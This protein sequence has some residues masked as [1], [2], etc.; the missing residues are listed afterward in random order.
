MAL[1]TAG[2]RSAASR[3]TIQLRIAL[4]SVVFVLGL[5]LIGAAS[6]IGNG[7]LTAAFEDH[8]AYS[9]LAARS[10]EVRAASFALKALSRDVR[11]RQESTDIKDFG[12]GLESLKQAITRLGSAAGADR[13]RDS[14]VALDAPMKAIEAD[15]TAIGAMQLGLRAPAPEG[16]AARLEEAAEALETK[17]RSNSMGS[18]SPD[19]ARLPGILAALRRIDASYRLSLDESLLGQW[20][21]EQG[22]FERALGRQGVSAEAKTEIGPAFTAY[23]EI[24]PAW[25]KAEKDFM[26]AAE[27]LSG[28]FD[29]IAP[30]LQ[31][32]ETRLAAEEAQ[33]GARLAEAQ[34]RTQAII[35]GTIAAALVLGLIAA[36]IVGRTTALPLR[37]LRDAMLKLAAGD[38]EVAI[39]G[40]SRRDEIGQMAQAVQVFKENGLSVQRLEAETSEGRAEAERQNL[41]I[42]RQREEAASAQAS[43]LTEQR[44]VVGLLAEALARL[45][46]GDLTVRIEDAVASDYETLK[47]DFNTAIERLAATVDAIKATSIEVATAGREITSGADD[48]SKRTEEQASSLEE[49]A[50]TTEELAASVKA[51]A[52]ASRQAAQ[53]SQDASGVARKGGAIVDD[54]V[55]AMTRIEEASRKI[56]DITSVIDEIAFQTNLLALNA[57]VEAARAGDAGRGFAVVASEVRILAQRSSEAAKD[58]SALIRTSNMQIGDGVELVRSAGAVLG[59]IVEAS[60]RV[61]ATVTEVSSAAAEQASGI[62]EMSQTIA[63]MDEMTQQNAALAEESAASATALGQQI[64]RLNALVAAFRTHDAGDSGHRVDLSRERRRA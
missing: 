61:A 52:G 55:Q 9:A 12:S 19:L 46:Q 47:Q 34:A 33:A 57:A 1:S 29:L 26:L 23:A 54:A 62:D 13:V 15:F 16:L 41:A 53:L 7:R 63:H 3:L 11:F 45:S 42:T 49:S 18:D 5:V 40:L 2:S 14:I 48:L 30:P 39:T 27:K 31:E 59:Q 4:V 8:K 36:F 43:L 20:E 24:V 56:S 51:A 10:R 64:E 28:Q 6:W 21:V 38:Y 17:V 35:L 44:E 50:A 22:R 32:L 58:I 37:R 60:Q 25:T